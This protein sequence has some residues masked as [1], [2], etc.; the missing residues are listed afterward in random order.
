LKK[1]KHTE[2]ELAAY[3]K[4]GNAKQFE[5]VYDY[6]SAALYGIINKILDNEEQSQDVLQEVFL[7]IWDGSASYNREKS[8]LFTWMLTIAR[9]SAIDYICSSQGKKEKKNQSADSHVTV[10]GKKSIG[11]KLYDTAGLK[12]AVN[13]LKED[14]KQIIDLIYFEGYT[15]DEVSKKLNIPLSTVKTRSRIALQLLRKQFGFEKVQF[16]PNKKEGY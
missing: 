2:E 11:N 16:S 14:Y 7:K 4:S 3:L 8:R 15:Q 1:N 5:T 9:N 13:E 10:P 6:F 12:K